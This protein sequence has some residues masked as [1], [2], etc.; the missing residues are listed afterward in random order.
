M[1]ETTTDGKRAARR[2][3]RPGRAPHVTR[4]PSPPGRHYPGIP[5]PPVPSLPP[6]PPL[7]AFGRSLDPAP[8]A[9]VPAPWPG[10]R[11]PRPPHPA[12][13]I[14]HS[15][16]PAPPRAH[17]H[18]RSAVG[19]GPRY[20]HPPAS[21]R[22]DFFPILS[23]GTPDSFPRFSHSFSRHVFFSHSF[24]RHFFPHSFS[25]RARFFPSF[26]FPDCFFLGVT[27]FWCP[28][29]FPRRADGCFDSPTIFSQRF[30]PRRRPASTP[31]ANNIF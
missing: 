15:F 16:T 24:S 20:R 27:S 3:A 26:F 14:L 10:P 22:A 21:A 5:T 8:P 6:P 25:Q 19:P 12:A 23:L 13:A 4:T 29:C 28:R 17:T 7:R 9:S 18:T 31:P 11:Y 30:P 2:P 1:H